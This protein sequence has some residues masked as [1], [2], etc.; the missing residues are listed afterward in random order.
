VLWSSVALIGA[1]LGGGLTAG[2]AAYGALPAPSVPSGLSPTTG[3]LLGAVSCV[4]SSFCVSVGPDVDGLL[5]STPYS[6]VWNGRTVRT[7][8]VPGRNPHLTGL[9]GISCTSAKNCVAVGGEDFEDGGQL[10][11]AWN[12]SSWNILPVPK[13]G[14]SDGLNGV[15][16]TGARTCI[17]VGSGPN[18]AMA[19]T[20]NGTSWHLTPRPVV[21]HRTLFSEFNGI[22]CDGPSRCLAVGDYAAP[23]TEGLT[24]LAE[25]W[26]GHS[27]KLLPAPP[28]VASLKGVACPSVKVCVAVGDD[29]A[30]ADVAS[31]RWNG[32]TWTELTTPGPP[33]KKDSPQVLS[34]VSCPSVTYC[35][36]AGS[37]PGISGGI[38]PTGAFAEKWTG[39]SAWTLLSVPDPPTFDFDGTV[40]AP[41]SL[42]GVSCASRTRCLAVGGDEDTDAISSYANFAVSWNGTSWRALRTGKVDL[43][44]GVACA[45]RA[46]CLTTGTYLAGNYSTRP[47]AEVWNGTSMRLVSPSG[48]PGVL[49]S[50]S[51]PSASFCMAVTGASVAIWNGKQWTSSGVGDTVNRGIINY[52][53]CVSR[54][55]CMAIGFGNAPLSEFWNGRA[56]HSARIVVPKRSFTDFFPGG[57]S[58]ATPSVC[59]AV[60][61]LQAGNGGPIGTFAEAWNGSTWRVLRSPFQHQLSDALS[62]V[63]CR[64]ATDCLTIGGDQGSNGTTLFTAR[65]NG[66][67]WKVTELPGTR[68]HIVWGDG[69]G[70]GSLSCPTATSCVAVGGESGNTDFTLIWNG[71][72][73]RTT[74][75]GGPSG[76]FEVSCAL[77]RQCVA[78]G[79]P[80]TTTLAKL[81]NGRTWRLINTI[82][83]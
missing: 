40:N 12:G 15:D 74:K 41:A 75:A 79:Q 46:Q 53:S 71:H 60:G 70:P 72:S 43:L 64:T 35:I 83:P 56:W 25:S 81:W 24:A 9:F 78:I 63:D 18:F 73:W 19:Q 59:L 36:A 13:K 65:W 80:G 33:V 50:A 52:L 68:R 17:A 48:L 37:G 61:S 42:A 58:C 14:S 62:A 29:G 4:G 32:S 27:W 11:D 20:W 28:D 49:S 10:S 54:D 26:N 57:L 1:L 66:Q 44:R 38:L 39:G 67:H 23:N 47:L 3:L 55:F 8:A 45:P 22:A 30:E 69:S 82:N 6:Q 21:P 5:F 76:I 16:C 31:A 34:S 77:A 51:C 2:Q 7:L